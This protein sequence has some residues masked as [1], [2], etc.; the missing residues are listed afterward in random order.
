[1]YYEMLRNRRSRR[2]FSD[3]E[4]E[5]EKLDI[6]LK[7]A[8]LSPSSKSKRPWEFVSVRDGETLK[9]LAL[10][11]P[12]GATP[13]AGAKLALVVLADPGISDVWIEDA[14]IAAILI[15]LA[16]ESQG[17][18]SCW[19][20]IRQRFRDEEVSAEEHVRKA[21]KIPENYCV[22]CII[23]IG[24]PAESKEPYDE[25]TLPYEKIHRERF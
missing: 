14:S 23:A 20:Q 24:Y 11:K 22:E 10:C 17:L 18:G 16:A 15:Q 5:D 25:S 9:K 2:V 4:V 21:L 1:M 8:L 12:H 19:I 7:S 3:R 13:I 6:I